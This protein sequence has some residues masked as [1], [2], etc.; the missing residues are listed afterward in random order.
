MKGLPSVS[1]RWLALAAL[2]AALLVVPTAGAASAASIKGVG[3]GKTTLGF[4]EFELSAHV[5]DDPTTPENGFGQVKVEYPV[6]TLWIDV[7]CTRVTLDGMGRPTATISGVVIRSSVPGIEPGGPGPPRLI[8]ARDGGEPSDAP[9]DRFAE[10][11]SFNPDPNTACLT[12]PVNIDSTSNVE[13][14]NI[15]VKL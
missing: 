9:V 3:A 1:P 11:F 14:G 10:A 6:G 8:F 5:E 13:Q 12:T 15:V 4:V 2:A 7:R